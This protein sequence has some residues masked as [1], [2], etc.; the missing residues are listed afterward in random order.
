MRI[1]Q[2]IDS[3]SYGGAERLLATL[4]SVAPDA[5]LDMTVTSLA[6]ASQGRNASLPV[7]EAAGLEPAYADVDKLLDPQGIPK[8]VRVIKASGCEVVHAHLGYSATLV[9]IA[10]RI[11]GVPCVS[12]LHHLPRR[13]DALSDKVKSWLCIQ[14]AERGH[15]LIFVSDAARRAAGQIYRPHPSWRTLHNGVDLT[16]FNPVDG[17][18]A[19]LP[20]DIDVPPGAPVVSIVAAVREPKG[21]EYAVA[22]WPK[23]RAQVPDAV[24]LIVGDG[25]HLPALRAKAE[26]VPGIVFTGAREDVPAILRGSTLAL[27][28]SLTEAL[29]TSLIEAA[30]TGLAVVATTVGGT[31]E[32]VEHGRTGILVEPRDSD[33]IATAVTDLLIDSARRAQY[34]AAGRKLAED[35]F[36]LRRWAGRL[37]DVYAEALGENDR[38]RTA[39][40]PGAIAKPEE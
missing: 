23:V 18:P 22:A 12:T 13:R 35:R 8:L 20:A 39:I 5:G 36:D 37:A 19:P 11:A 38:R 3:F 29:P 26:G 17:P 16:S 2:I 6:P 40:R 33:A 24:L 10:A 15:A 7:L 9:P 25:P 27:L 1:L 31:P 14:S 21:H 4:N 28:P 30:A 34:G 32:T